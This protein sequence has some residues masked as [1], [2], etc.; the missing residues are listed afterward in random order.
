MVLPLCVSGC[1]SLGGAGEGAVA[2]WSTGDEHI[3][4]CLPTQVKERPGWGVGPLGKG[5]SDCQGTGPLHK[6]PPECFPLYSQRWAGAWS[7][8]GR[9]LGG[10]HLLA[11]VA[12]CPRV[13]HMAGLTPLY[14]TP[15][16]S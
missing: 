12:S 11:R 15:R 6:A 3:H 13:G 5:P 7:M 10:C 16:L 9:G 2:F 1:W 14:S 4:R 8:E